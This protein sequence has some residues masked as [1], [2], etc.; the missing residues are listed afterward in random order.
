MNNIWLDILAKYEENPWQFINL[1]GRVKF[2]IGGT[3]RKRKQIRCDSETDSIVWMREDMY[4]THII[5]PDSV[6][7]QGFLIGGIL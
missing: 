2:P 4:F 6:W 7:N 5:R 1:Q 3:V